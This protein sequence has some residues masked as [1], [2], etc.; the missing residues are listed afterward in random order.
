MLLRQLS[1]IVALPGV[2]AIAVPVWIARRNGV[3]LA[4][5][6]NLQSLA[7]QLSGCALL[8]VGFWLFSASLYNFWKRGYGPGVLILDDTD[9]RDIP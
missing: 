3:E 7:L 5:A 2:V 9:S 1:A 6:H 8:I 4:A